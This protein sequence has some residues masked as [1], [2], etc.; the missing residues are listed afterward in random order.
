[1][2]IL[3]IIVQEAE[4]AQPSIFSFNLGVSFW[5]VVIFLLLLAI[6]AKFAFPAILGYAEEREKRIQAILD[7]AAQDREEAARALEEQKRELAESRQ[8]AQQILADARQAAERIR[9]EMLEQAR[10]EQE[11]LVARARQELERERQRAIETLRRE[12][13][14]RSLAA[15]GRLIGERL[16]SERDR[17]LVRGYLEQIDAGTGVGA[18]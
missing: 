15:A 7:A 10:A 5:T 3:S 6:L 13:V 14:E 9:D 1:M 18:A 8:K 16:D 2:T 11:A 4:Q 12:A 17:E